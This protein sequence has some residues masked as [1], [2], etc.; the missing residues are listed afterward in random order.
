MSNLI[1]FTFEQSPIRIIDQQ[2]E[3]WFVANDVCNVLEI[4]NTTQALQSLDDDEKSKLDTTSSPMLNIALDNRVKEINIINESG[5]Y[6]LIL[7]SRK[8]MQ[9]GTVQHK[10]R[11]WV[12]SEVLPS[13]R[14]TGQ[15]TAP[16][17][18]LSPK[19]QKALA[20]K[21]RSLCQH[22]KK[23][24]SGVWRAIKD[25]FG[26]ER[27]QDILASDFENALAF[28]DT[29]APPS[30]TDYPFFLSQNMAREFSA[31]LKHI[32]D[33]AELVGDNKPAHLMKIR[34]K[35]LHSF[36]YEYQKRNYPNNAPALP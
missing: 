22:D 29:I 8:A 28:L 16:R 3:F 30:P 10:F 7:R 9:K 4:Q 13:I 21:V 1:N 5:L 31:R 33:L 11:K 14:K 26:V 2:G 27:Y 25:H 24:Y 6:T 36:L 34:V 32:F 20:D 23:A 15:Y 35:E 12:T 18:T 19:E 17:Q